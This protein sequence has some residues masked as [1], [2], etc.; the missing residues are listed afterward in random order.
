MKKILL[1]ITV[2]LLASGLTLSYA[3]ESTANTES[4]TA[5][6]PRKKTTKKRSTTRKSSSTTKKEH[7]P[8]LDIFDVIQQNEDKLDDFTPPFD[9]ATAYKYMAEALNESGMGT[10]IL[11]DGYTVGAGKV[12]KDQQVVLAVDLDCFDGSRPTFIAFVENGKATMYGACFWTGRQMDQFEMSMHC[13]DCGWHVPNIA[14]K[15]LWSEKKELPFLVGVWNA[16]TD[17]APK[18]RRQTLPFIV[19]LYK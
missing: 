13:E 1:L 15:Y 17:E 16:T 5:A 3:A 8:G 19:R 11:K 12:G 6:A 14:C 9:K 7:Y 18:S 10:D 2:A 4:S